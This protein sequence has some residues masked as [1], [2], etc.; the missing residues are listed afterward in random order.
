MKKLKFS[1]LAIRNFTYTS[2]FTNIL[3]N[4][5]RFPPINEFSST[6]TVELEKRLL[7]LHPEAAEY[8]NFRQE[9]TS[10]DS[11]SN[12]GYETHSVVKENEENSVNLGSGSAKT[13]TSL[14]AGTTSTAGDKDATAAISIAAAATIARLAAGKSHAVD[15][16]DG[17]VTQL[18]GKE[19]QMR[20]KISF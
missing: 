9:M 8:A 11:R 7:R 10:P 14:A 1:K 19:Y 16:V 6:L 17:K 12:H 13:E 2:Y 3:P 15:E 4:T 20:K 18:L 5:W